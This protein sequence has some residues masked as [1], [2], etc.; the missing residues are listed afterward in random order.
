MFLTAQL[1]LSTTLFAEDTSEP[2]P[3]PQ[4]VLG[5]TDYVEAK[6]LLSKHKWEE[7]AIILRLVLKKNP[8]LLPGANELARALVYSGRR[9]E[10]L[11]VLNQAASHQTGTRKEALAE[12]ARVISRLFLTYKTRQIYQEGLNL[13]DAKKYR[14]A[15]ERFEQALLIEP[16]NIEILTRIG[17]CFVFDGDFDSAAERLR[18]AKRLD[19]FEPEIQLWLGRALQERG[20]LTAA[21]EELRK[22]HERLEHSERAPIWYADALMAVGS[23]KTAVSILEEDIKAEPFHLVEILSLAKL[24][25]ELFKDGADSLW[26]ARRDLQVALSRL[27]KYGSGDLARAEGEL[28]VE[29]RVPVE[30]LKTEIQ[31]LLAQ[32]DGRLQT[33]SAGLLPARK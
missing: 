18:I 21:L 9:E 19:P 3:L 11:S 30:E 20:E 31:G 6:Q 10:A 23:R 27:G 13:L 26:T 32:L 16:D 33:G 22:A 25:I 29:M 17:Q 15:R 14:T 24:R 1:L 12:R 4:E 5:H 7:A 2:D 8:T 28:G